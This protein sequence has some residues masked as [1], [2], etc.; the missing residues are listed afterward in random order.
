MALFPIIVIKI[1]LYM[2]YIFINE[3][4]RVFNFYIVAL[5]TKK[6]VLLLAQKMNLEYNMFHTSCH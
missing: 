6:V 5:G 4:I 3:D 2:S 1:I